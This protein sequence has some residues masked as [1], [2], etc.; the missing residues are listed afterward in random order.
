MHKQRPV[1]EW[2]IAENDAEWERRCL[3]IG[4]ESE[5]VATPHPRPQRYFWRGAALLLLFVA[6]GGWQR[7][8]TQDRMP[9][10]TVVVTERALGKLRADA[11]VGAVMTAN[12]PNDPNATGWWPQEA[13]AYISL[14]TALQTT[15]LIGHGDRA[16]S[17]VELGGGRGLAHIVTTAAT[18]AP[19]YRQT[20]FYRRSPAGWVQTEPVAD[21]WGAERSLETTFF[22]F[23]F[24]QN[25]TP[26]VTAVAPQLDALYTSLR[27]NF[28]LPISLM[29]LPIA[30]GGEKLHIDVRITHPTGAP[31]QVDALARIR[32]SSP[33]LYVAPVDLTDAELL[34]QA[35]ALP[36]LDQVLAQASEHH[37][38]GASWRSM[39]PGLHLWQLW[40]LDLPLAAWR[41]EVVMPCH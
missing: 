22:V 27:R 34:A 19:A 33:A 40:A 17:V 6:V 24:Q 18:G 35:I 10:D 13:R 20:R 31:N 9:L 1:L 11:Q 12:R 32:V 4:A 16:I 25:D 3:L 39:L 26:A 23:H 41:E 7:S 8:T 15:K 38:I 21:L 37:A 30:L 28:G 5:P 29:N 14:S 2:T 36:L